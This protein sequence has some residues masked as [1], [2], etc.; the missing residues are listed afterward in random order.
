LQE[1]AKPLKKDR[2]VERHRCTAT[3]IEQLHE[4]LGEPLEVI[5]E[6]NP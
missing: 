2:E 3:R 6:V 4:D 5:D 1:R